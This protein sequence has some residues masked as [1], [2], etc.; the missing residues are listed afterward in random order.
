MPPLPGT[1][2]LEIF[3]AALVFGVVMTLGK[4]P[5]FALTGLTPPSTGPSAPGA[6]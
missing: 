4:R 6:G 1:L 3:A 2:V 5:L